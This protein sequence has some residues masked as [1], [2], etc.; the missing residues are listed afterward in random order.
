MFYYWICDLVFVSTASPCRKRTVNDLEVGI[1]ANFNLPNVLLLVTLK[2]KYFQIF[3][4]EMRPQMIKMFYTHDH[5]MHAS[6][7]KADV[8]DKSKLPDT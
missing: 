8:I 5:S 3:T 1:H 2:Q 6:F 7:E 4:E